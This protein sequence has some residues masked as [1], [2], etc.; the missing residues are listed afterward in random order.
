MYPRVTFAEVTLMDAKD[1]DRALRATFW[2]TLKAHGFRHRTGRVAWR[3]LGE[4]IDVV[5][6]QAVGQDAEVVGCPP[7]SLSV[8]AA[9]FPPYMDRRDAVPVRDGRLRPH[10]W[11]CDPFSWSLHKTLSQ[12]WFRPFSEQRDRRKLPSF[13]VHREALKQLIDRSVHDQP[14]IWYMR[15]DGSNLEENIHDLTSVVISDGLDHI[16]RYRD[17]HRVIEMIDDGSF[18]DPTS[19][20]AFYLR[21]DVEDYLAAAVPNERT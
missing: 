16:D 4:H 15:D 13:R 12:P 11:H 14:D 3:Y 17:P 1:L 18:I 10:Y 20:R 2:P 9:K 5:E 6:L 19:P 8:F 7:L 21:Q